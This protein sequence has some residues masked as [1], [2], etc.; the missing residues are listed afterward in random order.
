MQ[1]VPNSEKK[2]HEDD[3]L[4]TQQ[5]YFDNISTEEAVSILFTIKKVALKLLK[6]LLRSVIFLLDCTA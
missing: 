2:N 5:Y 4:T 3:D 6:F 1:R